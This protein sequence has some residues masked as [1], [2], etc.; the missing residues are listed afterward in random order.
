MISHYVILRRSCIAILLVAGCAARA[1]GQV[2]PQV[3]I[4]W[5]LEVCAETAATLQVAGSD[6]FAEIASLDGDQYGGN[7]GFAYVWPLSTQFRVQNSLAR[8]DPTTYAPLLRQFSD[9][10]RTRY[11]ST[12]GGGYRSGVGGGSTRFYDDNA[13]IAVALMEAYRNTADPVY[14]SRAQETYNFV[15]SGEDAVGGGGIYFHEFDHSTKET[16]RRC[17]ARERP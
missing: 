9:E 16:I 5:G 11:W 13:H 14:L 12:V 2:S 6:L 1:C 7:G 4:D 10:A 3:M 15:I 8:I 17:R